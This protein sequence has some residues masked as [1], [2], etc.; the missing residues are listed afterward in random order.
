MKQ[1]NLIFFLKRS[2][3]HKFV[4]EKYLKKH[5]KNLLLKNIK[6]KHNTNIHHWY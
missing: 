3:I 6:K 4:I 2:T 5:M 1:K